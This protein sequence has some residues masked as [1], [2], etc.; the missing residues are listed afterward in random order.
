MPA[1]RKQKTE[2]IRGLIIYFA[3]LI[4]SGIVLFFLLDNTQQT[5]A[6][7]I[8]LATVFGTLIFWKFRVA[9]AFLGFVL[10]LLSGTIDVGTATEFMDLDV[11]LFLV[12]MMVLVGVLRES[13]FFRW[14]VYRVLKISRF[15]PYSLMIL[16]LVMS[17]ITAALVDEVT[18]TLFMSALILDLCDFFGVNPTKFIISAVLATNIG[19]SWTV[20]GNPIGILIALRSGLTFIDFVK[21]P[22]VIGFISLI[23]LIPVILLWMRKD[24]HELEDNMILKE[25]DS[26]SDF[27][28]AWAQVKDKGVLIGSIVIFTVV[29]ILLAIDHQL[30]IWLGLPANTLLIATPIFGAAIV[31]LWKRDKA[32]EYIQKDVDWWTLVFFMFLFAEA[33]ALHF[34]SLA[35][36]IADS[37]GGL[38]GHLGS[39]IIQLGVLWLSSLTSAIVDNVVA[40]AALIPVAQN[41]FNVLGSSIWWALLFGGTYGGNL[42]MVGSTANIVA[43]GILEKKAHSHVTLWSWLKIGFWGFLIPMVTASVALII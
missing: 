33:G 39:N 14:L 25:K 13:G 12:G 2:D 38:S 35:N 41:L 31:M 29:V 34:V 37:I 17:S 24:I 26:M 11:I 10:L 21:F 9:I 5:I 18:S 6:S 30:E 16:I 23:L 40:V 20:L 19:S 32:Q 8:F 22:L 4:S 3:L 27:L 15:Q 28:S 7:T 36:R 1:T 42:T 43:L